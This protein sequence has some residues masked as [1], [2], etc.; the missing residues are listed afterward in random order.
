MPP[1][2]IIHADAR[3]GGT[4]LVEV[5]GCP[6]AEQAG[7]TRIHRIQGIYRDVRPPEKLVFSWW[8]EGWDF[9][10]TVVTVEFRKLGQSNFTEISLI[11]E[12]LPEKEREGH[13][14][15]WERCFDLLE[16]TL[17]NN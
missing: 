12:W 4:F 3:V 14:K 2:K 10:E 6:P 8:F 15:G 1:V 7:E 16:K 5:E 9:K 11:H 17:A 13:R